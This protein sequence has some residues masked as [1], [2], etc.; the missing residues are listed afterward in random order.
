MLG[1]GVPPDHLAAGGAHH[2]GGA[3]GGGALPDALLV[4]GLTVEHRK[5]RTMLLSICYQFIIHNINC[6][7]EL[8]IKYDLYQGFDGPL[9]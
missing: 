2:Q 9:F 4:V 8:E 3:G 7:I 1:E 5:V 6:F